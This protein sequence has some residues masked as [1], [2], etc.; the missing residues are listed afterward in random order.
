MILVPRAARE[1]RVV[2]VSV[3]VAE[4]EASLRVPKTVLQLRAGDR[5][6]R[7]EFVLNEA[8]HLLPILVFE[9]AQEVRKV[10]DRF[11]REERL[12]IAVAFRNRN[13]LRFE[14]LRRVD[15][16]RSAA[17]ERE[18][19]DFDRRSVLEGAERNADLVVGFRRKER[20]RNGLPIFRRRYV[21]TNADRL[22]RIV[23]FD[24]ADRNFRLAFGTDFE[25]KSIRRT[26]FDAEPDAVNLRNPVDGADFGDV[27]PQ[28]VRVD[29]GFARRNDS[30]TCF[31]GFVELQLP[32]TVE[33]KVRRELAV[34]DLLGAG[35][36]VAAVPS[37]AELGGRAV[38]LRKPSVPKALELVAIRRREIVEL[39]PRPR[40]DDRVFVVDFNDRDARVVDVSLAGVR[41]DV[42]QQVAGVLL[43]QLDHSRVEVVDALVL[44]REVFRVF[45]PV[46]LV[47]RSRNVQVD[48]DV[49]PFFLKA[50]DHVVELVELFRVDF[51]SRFFEVGAPNV[52]AVHMVQSDDADPEPRKRTS[53]ELGVFF[54]REVAAETEV[55]AEEARVAGLEREPTV[56]RSEKSS[57]SGVRKRIVP[58]LDVGDV[59]L[60]AVLDNER[61]FSRVVGEKRRR[62]D[63]TAEKRRERRTG[64]FFAHRIFLNRPRASK[65]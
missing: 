29:S 36:V 45:E 30:P 35:R 33:L 59:A 13:R 37:G 47:E 32:R 56:F 61:E 44:R 12:R 19:G 1:V 27:E 46:A 17:S 23:I 54:V 57:R 39:A 40:G 20:N 21:A 50:I 25:R 11:R 58:S 62:T 63:E 2:P 14:R 22:P 24:D 28:R 26:L 15:A 42:R 60:R 52:A 65:R 49:N 53:E 51:R 18:V 8:I 55:R 31:R 4:V 7:A 43:L 9:I 6:F 3:N 38:F 41:V 48:I 10:G 64:E 5:L 34:G 16:E